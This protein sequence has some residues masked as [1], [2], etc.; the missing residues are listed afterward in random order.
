MDVFAD[1]CGSGIGFGGTKVEENK[2]AMTGI[3]KRLVNRPE[4]AQRNIAKI[5]THLEGIQMDQITTVLEIGC[6]IGTVTNWLADSYDLAVTGTD[7][8]PEQITR[9]KKMYPEHERLTFQVEDGADLSFETDYFDLVI[10]Q[11]V[12]HHIK[13]WRSA[14]EEIA[15]VLRPGGFFIWY[16]LVFPSWLRVVFSRFLKN[17][18]FY[19]TTDVRAEFLKNGFEIKSE[20]RLPHGLFV[21][22]DIL[23]LCG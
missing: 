9:A 14:V 15:R 10:S 23:L 4:K 18:G 21:H 1:P 8:D 3:E 13:N 6:G 11:N 5:A 2:M 19:T 7:F 17:Y 12:F 16:D 20:K 22:Y